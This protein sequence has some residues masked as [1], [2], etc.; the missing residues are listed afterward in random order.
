MKPQI[1]R[2]FYLLIALAALTLI[3]C[4]ESEEV[5]DGTRDNLHVQIFDGFMILPNRFWL[6]TRLQS[7]K[8]GC[9]TFHSFLDS[10]A[11]FV[12][13]IYFCSHGEAFKDNEMFSRLKS[14]EY[15]DR[16]EL[17]HL[18]YEV[19]EYV[20]KQKVDATPGNRI[21]KVVVVTK[22]SDYAV[23]LGITDDQFWK[24]LVDSI[25]KDVPL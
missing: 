2:K 3:S 11:S 20:K 18:D 23:F 9:S 10:K 8:R 13:S 24:N 7:T 17:T 16:N 15:T 12:G 14:L 22:G 6:D 19:I 5:F 1:Q 25:K 4:T 21:T